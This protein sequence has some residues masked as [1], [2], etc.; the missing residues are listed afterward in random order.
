M[1]KHFS[2]KTLIHLKS[3]K[4]WDFSYLGFMYCLII[5]FLNPPLV[6]LL[7]MGINMFWRSY[8]WL[9][10]IKPT[11]CFSL[12]GSSNLATKFTYD[13]LQWSLQSA[14]VILCFLVKVSIFRL[15]GS[16]VWPAQM[17]HKNKPIT[18][19]VNID[20]LSIF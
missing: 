6:F 7:G 19:F 1:L 4:K 16:T 20:V 14:P 13:N 2:Y 3:F 8:S 11:I 18:G 9:S 10:H 17:M 5:W 12:T 15:Q